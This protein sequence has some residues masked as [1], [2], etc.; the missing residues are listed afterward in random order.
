MRGDFNL[1]Y[2]T[3][4]RGRTAASLLPR[5]REAARLGVGLI[6]IREKDLATL[7]LIDLLKGS[8][9]A[10]RESECRLVVN[11][12]LDLALALGARGV[13]L[14]NQSI[15]AR[16]VRACIPTDF[17]MGVSSHSLEEVFAAEAAGADYALFGPVF[18]TPSKTRYG[19][20]LGLEKLAE[21]AHRATIPLLALGGITVERVKACLAAGARGVA[22]ISIFQ[23]ADSLEERVRAIRRQMEG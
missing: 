6:Q 12:R 22:G 2:I 23:D 14:G 8:M 7:E 19:P 10:V 4:R 3:D 9:E 20:P 16:A 18:S 5:V 21:A 11:D 1:C 15:P 17:L 13:H